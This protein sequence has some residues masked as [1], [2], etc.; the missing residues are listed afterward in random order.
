MS[1]SD[2]EHGLNGIP[3]A[4]A[5]LSALDAVHTSAMLR[6]PEASVVWA[7][8]A[9]D[10]GPASFMLPAIES[11]VA[12][13]DA[14]SHCRYPPRGVRGTAHPIVCTSAYGF[15]DSFL[16][17]CE[18]DTLVI[19]QVETVTGIAEIDAIAAVDGLDV[20]QMG[21]LD[22]SASMGYLWDP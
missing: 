20:V 14:V 15:D 9:L 1:L 4:L 10:L 13:A 22:L 3:E 19:C 2:M 17:H 11:P 21:P 6:L 12:A 18:D 8:K 16:S 7:K 5:Y